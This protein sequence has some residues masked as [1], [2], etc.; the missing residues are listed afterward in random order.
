MPRRRRKCGRRWQLPRAGLIGLVA[1]VPNQ[2]QAERAELQPSTVQQPPGVRQAMPVSVFTYAA[3]TGEVMAVDAR[4]AADVS[5]LDGNLNL[6][7]SE[8]RPVSTDVPPAGSGTLT[9]QPAPD[10]IVVPAGTPHQ[11]KEVSAPFLYYVVKVR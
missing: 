6:W 8:N 10:V 11:F 9:V 5:L 2:R 7:R 1:L 3:G 4:N